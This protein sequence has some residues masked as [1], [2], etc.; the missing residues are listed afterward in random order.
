[1]IINDIEN[2]GKGFSLGILLTA[3]L[4][5]TYGTI[6][7]LNVH[8]WDVSFNPID[9]ILKPFMIVPFSYLFITLFINRTTY[10]FNHL[11]QLSLI[12]KKHDGKFRL[13]LVEK[14]LPVYII[15][16]SYLNK[17]L[18]IQNTLLVDM[19][20]KNTDHL[21]F[22]DNLDIFKLYDNQNH[23]SIRYMINRANLIIKNTAFKDK[24]I[25]FI[26]DS[27]KERNRTISK[28]WLRLIRNPKSRS[29]KDDIHTILNMVY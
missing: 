3:C 28:I 25:T 29:A 15:D 12:I 13:K 17:N 8:L 2:K 21:S 1:M 22:K 26:I 16:E 24:S 27:K 14:N 20:I 6:N 19:R 4:I 18:D 11:K 10:V 23:V 7:L 5:F 9:S